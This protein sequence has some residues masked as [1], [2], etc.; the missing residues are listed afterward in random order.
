MGKK[1]TKFYQV[2]KDSE[3]AFSNPIGDQIAHIILYGIGYSF[4]LLA[5]FNLFLIRRLP[6]I[7]IIASLTWIAII[8]VLIVA[9]CRRIGI[10]QHLIDFLGSFIRNRFIE[11]IKK[12]SNTLLLCFGYVFASKRFYFL[13]IR[14]DGIKAIDWNLGQAS[15]MTG[16]DMNDW[17]VALWFNVSAVEYNEKDSQLGIYIVG[18]SGSRDKIETFGNELID[19]LCRN[20]ID[21]I[22]PPQDL[23]NKEGVVSEALSPVGKITIE[24]KEYSAHTVKGAVKTGSRIIV[25]ELRGTSIYAIK[26]EPKT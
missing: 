9:S 17:S 18:P 14:A 5:L 26:V 11:I 12:D 3:I 6:A 8:V 24:N 19:F 7:S 21:I 25:K 20:Q 1:K 13:K 15:N 22:L 4:F 10:R 23:L 2:V 16:K